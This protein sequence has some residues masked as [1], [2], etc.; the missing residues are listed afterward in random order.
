M[1]R[2]PGKKQPLASLIREMIDH[3]DQAELFE[4][5]GALYRAQWERAMA[6]EFRDMCLYRSE[7]EGLRRI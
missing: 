7:S 1:N 4:I 5:V 2:Q 3:L 6:E